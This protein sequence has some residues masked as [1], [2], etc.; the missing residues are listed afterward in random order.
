MKTK[1]IAVIFDMDGVIVHNDYFHCLAWQKFSHE[2]NIEVS[3]EQ[4][5]SWFG[6]TNA[7]ILQNLFGNGLKPEEI[8]KMAF[9]KESIYRELYSAEIAPVRGLIDFLDELKRN[10]IPVA[11]ATAAPVENVNFVLNATKTVSYFKTI[12]DESQITSGK[13]SPE[14]FL[15]AAE[16]L[17]IAPSRCVVFEDSFFGII[18]GNKAGMKVIGVATSHDAEKLDNTVLNIPD[19]NGI[20]LG[21]IRNIMK[22][23]Q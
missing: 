9:R 23:K 7:T 6:N 16:A 13:P 15:K 12:I 17:N 10:H 22:S 14:I 21:M 3:T 1:G 2:N 5:K 18:A 20:N 8:I 4:I 19:F 11:L